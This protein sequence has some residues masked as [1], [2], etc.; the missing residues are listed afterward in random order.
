MVKRLLPLNLVLL[1][2]CAIAPP[3]KPLVKP[4]TVEVPVYQ[5]VRCPAPN[6]TRPAMPIAKLK[7]DSTP[8]D[9]MRAYAATVA[10]L[11]GAV[12]ERDEVIAGCVNPVKEQPPGL[13]TPPAETTGA[14]FKS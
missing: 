13:S 7:A 1:G 6:L 2:A 9:T 5:P 4:T 12:R 8:A 3:S 14:D 10:I 11:K